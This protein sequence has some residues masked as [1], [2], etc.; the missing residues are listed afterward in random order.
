MV[1]KLR[2]PC[3]GGPSAYDRENWVMRGCHRQGGQSNGNDAAEA[4]YPWGVWMSNGKDPKDTQPAT[5]TRLTFAP[6]QLAPVECVLVGDHVRRQVPV[7]NDQ[8]SRSNRYLINT[9]MVPQLK[10]ER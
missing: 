8:K 1:G 6:G 5:I 9:A 2:L 7:L 4:V 3:P 10:E